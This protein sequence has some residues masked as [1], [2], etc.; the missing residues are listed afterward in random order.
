MK[1]RKEEKHYTSPF[2][3][4]GFITVC[5]VLAMLA[6]CDKQLTKSK[7][8]GNVV[9]LTVTT[10]RISDNNNTA[11]ITRAGS[12]STPA[13]QTITV[14]IIGNGNMALEA[15]LTPS[16]QAATELAT[17]M[18]YRVIAFE[19]DNVTAA[20]YKSH[21]DYAVGTDE[22]VAG[23]LRVTSGSTYT[24]VC[25][26]LNSSAALPAFDA[27]NLNIAAA[28]STNDLLYTKFNQN[29]TQANKTLS[30]SFSHKFSQVT[31]IADAT[32]L[33][34]N[35][36]A[37]S[38]TLSPNYPASMALA[39]GALTAGTAAARSIPWGT[40]T[41]GETVTANAC[42]VFTNSSTAISVNIPSVT[43]GTTTK[44]NLTATFGANAMQQ[45][46]KY[47]LR[48]RFKEYGIVLAGLTWAPGNLIYTEGTYSFA[49]TQEYHT[50]TWNGGD[51]WN[52]CRTDP[53]V[54]TSY[55]GS[56]SAS[57]DPCQKV[58]PAGTWRMPTRAEF[59][60]L[61]SAGHVW[62]TKIGINGRY[63]GTTTVQAA[64]AKDN[65]L[66]L[67]AAGIRFN[68]TT[69][70]GSIDTN[71]YY[72]AATSSDTSNAYRLDFSNTGTNMYYNT[73][74][75]GFSIRCVK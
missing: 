44:T 12:T 60:S 15:T 66:F 1:K 5:M 41:A 69:A 61:I 22:P 63:F 72:W 23:D 47:T 68:G 55:T 13:P 16:P 8:A 40:V 9:S 11:E 4:I 33:A 39:D 57:V 24:F 32:N 35:I 67:P 64:K 50:S 58:A 70:I 2:I 42:T 19:Q 30:F 10:P 36:T 52:W 56:Y 6:G 34:Q 18:K 74:S 27:N 51:Y 7:A 20:G 14:P 3:A 31:V 45:G 49:D 29:I 21:A 28:P 48:L 25:Y 46:Y 37:I 38:T 17:G 43:I 59:T 71:G 65:F 75:S 73:R 62:A 26:S 53:T 54:L